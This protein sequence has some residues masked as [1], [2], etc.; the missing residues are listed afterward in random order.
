MPLSSLAG[1]RSAPRSPPPPPRRLCACSAR[2]VRV[3]VGLGLGLALG[4]GLGLGL[5]LGF[6]LGEGVQR[7]PELAVAHDVVELEPLLESGQP[8][9]EGLAGATWL[10][11]GPGL[12]FGLGFGFGVGVGVGVGLV[13]RGVT[14][15]QR[16]V[17]LH[18][19]TP[20]GPP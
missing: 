8:R 18:V 14:A 20:H 9:A 17:T 19:L 3:R 13:E 11:L 7:A 12:G 6:G 16:G 1:L 10:G 15:A 2:L 4:S 5:G